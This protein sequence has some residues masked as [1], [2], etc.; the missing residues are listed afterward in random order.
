[1]L[2]IDPAAPA[3][4]TQARLNAIFRA[5]ERAHFTDARHAILLKPGRHALDINVGFFTQVAG[6]G[7]TPPEVQVAGHVHAEA[8]WA[9]G[10]ALVNFWR[11]V[12]NLSV[13]PPD[14][15]DR[16]AVSQAA[17]YRR[18]ELHGDLALDDGGWSSG[19]FL[20]DCAISGTIR[21]GTQQQWFSR[22]S[23]IGGWQGANWNMMFAGVEGAPPTTFPQP[24]VTALPSVPL[25]R[26]KPFL[27]CTS[28]GG[29]QV[30]VPALRREARGVSWAGAP[31]G[32]SLPLTQFLIARPD[33][34]LATI[35]AG[36]RAGRH[37]LLTPGIYRLPA[38]IRVTRPGTVVLGLGLATLLPV[39]GTA[40]LVVDDVAGVSVAGLLID[41]GA[42]NSPLL[43]QVGQRGTRVRHAA[44][45]ILLAD[46]FFRVGG[47][48]VGK[49]GTCLEVN[50]HH[51]IGDHLWIWRADHGDRTS[52][53][54]HHGWTESIADHGLVVNGNDVSMYGLFVEHFQKWQTVWNGERGR[55]W[56]Y[57]NEL[58]YD[59]PSQR[60][61][62]A[63]SDRGW[64]AYKVAD[65]VRE[66][67]A[68]GMGVYANF[69]ADPS[70]VLASA[71]E[72]PQTPGVRVE[73]VTTISLGGGKGTIAHL[74][75][76]AGAAARPGAIRQTLPRYPE[77]VA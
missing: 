7:L 5:Q 19:G 44:D 29:W 47:A 33:T 56:F 69:T 32:R 13:R 72:V 54:E 26:E 34:P 11:G 28:A 22:T 59:P 53:R 70:I 50:S 68:I 55:T 75:N 66:H 8:D 27:C 3:A 62:R 45:P 17:P 31:A 42:K 25:I 14:G 18:V 64:A 24:P 49:A 41:A 35:N 73:N 15:A 4:E 61:W 37:L 46:L 60:G 63:D 36:L 20:A 2:V 51:L 76:D 77:P 21:S 1:M 23:R 74:V 48:T 67:E 38:P 30:F 9:N 6:L 39:N 71:V 10:M 58:P 57:Q 16:W 43:M 40:A 12:E 52:G 65:H